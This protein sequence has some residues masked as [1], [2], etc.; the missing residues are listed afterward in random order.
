MD[1]NKTNVPHLTRVTKSCQSLWCLLAHLTGCLVRGTGNF[2]FFDFMQFPN[3]CN[4][5]L[6]TLLFT[7][8]EVTK[9]G[10]LP[11][12]LRLQKDNCVRENKNI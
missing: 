8:L 2:G 9:R 6:T 3:D 1:Q 10:Y 4:L 5:T 7:L 11:S 12:H